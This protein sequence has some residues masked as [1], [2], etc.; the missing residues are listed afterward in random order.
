M[1]EAYQKEAY[2]YE[3]VQIGNFLVSIGYY[4]K[5]FDFSRPISINLF[6][7]TGKKDYTI[8][9]LFGI[10]PGKNF[11]IEFKSD[12][13]NIS[14][15]RNKPQRKELLVRLQNTEYES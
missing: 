3:N 5:C 4:L 1:K 2:Q 14:S 12:K 13:N 7:Q 8:G 9:D 11:I 15:E 10:F 6:Q